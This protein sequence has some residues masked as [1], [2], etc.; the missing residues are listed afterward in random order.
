MEAPIDGD[1]AHQLFPFEP[2]QIRWTH[3]E[4][5]R[6]AGSFPA[7]AL[8]FIESAFAYQVGCFECRTASLCITNHLERNGETWPGA[9]ACVL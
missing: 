8:D 5:I 1:C 9:R 7:G 2:E 6:P 4:V 3:M